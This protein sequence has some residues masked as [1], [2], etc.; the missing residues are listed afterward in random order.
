MLSTFKSL[1][2]KAARENLSQDQLT[3]EAGFISPKFQEVIKKIPKN[4]FKIVLYWLISE[5][6]SILLNKIVS[7]ENPT[8]IINKTET[9]NYYNIERGKPDISPY[10]KPKQDSTKDDQPGK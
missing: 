3:K 10:E 6:G 4:I 2:E 7:D 1:T 5:L 9:H 8:L